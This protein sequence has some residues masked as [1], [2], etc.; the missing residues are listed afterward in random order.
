MSERVLFGTFLYICMRAETVNAR[1]YIGVL[2]QRDEDDDFVDVKFITLSKEVADNEL[3][4]I[5]LEDNKKT[6]YET[7][8]EYSRDDEIKE[9]IDLFFK[10]ISSWKKESEYLELDELIWKIYIDTGYYN[11]VSLM[12]DGILKLINSFSNTFA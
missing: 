11:Y 10:K 6:F 5:R 2:H 1:L 4:Q 9:K 3:I 8:K 12:P 7:M